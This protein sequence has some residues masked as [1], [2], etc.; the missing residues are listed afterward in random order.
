[1]YRVKL[2][3][4]EGPLSLLLELVEGRKL[5][6]NEVS[7]AHVTDQYLEYLKTATGFPTEE[8]AGFVAIAATLMLIKSASLIPSLELTEEEKGDIKELERR[9]ELYRR[10]RELSQKIGKIFGKT[11]MFNREPFSGINFGFIEPKGITKGKLFSALKEIVSNLPLKEVLPEAMVKKTI[12]LEKKM[13]ELLGRVQRQF[14]FHFSDLAASKREKIEI[15]ISFLAVLELIKREFIVV[16][17]N[18][19]FENIRIKKKI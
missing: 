8:V 14:E 13:E 18:T 11:P 15:I 16:E 17:Q 3:K 7:L 19:T 9:L 10:I 6:I 2:E 12:S 4:F 5:S 1:M